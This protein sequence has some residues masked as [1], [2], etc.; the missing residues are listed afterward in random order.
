VGT[1]DKFIIDWEQMMADNHQG[2]KGPNDFDPWTG[3]K[4]EQRPPDLDAL[5]RKFLQQIKG[6]GQKQMPLAHRPQ[7]LNSKKYLIILVIFFAIWLVS[8]FF[9]VQPAERAVILRFGE[10]INTLGPGPHWIP[11]LIERRFI[12]NE[13]KVE[14]YSYQANMLT[15]DQTIVSVAISVFYR[16]GNAQAYLFNVVSPNQSLQQATASALR[17]VIGHN[18][19]DAV[20]TY[21]RSEIR[22]QVDSQLRTLLARYNTGL[23]ITDVVLQ[24][25]RAPEQ[26][27]AAFDDAIKAQEDEQRLINQAQAYAMKIVP[28]A[29][30]AAKRLFAEANAYKEKVTLQATGESTRFLALLNEYQK[31]P[32]VTRERLYLQTMEKILSNTNKVIVDSKQSQP[33]LYLPLDKMMQNISKEASA[34]TGENTPSTSATGLRTNA[35]LKATQTNSN[36]YP[37]WPE[38]TNANDGRDNP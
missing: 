21:G 8:G 35:S 15:K 14:T 32:R 23:I 12:V 3:R 11:P 20:L 4:R 27:K 29:E 13:E 16:V 28:L 25:A 22:Q 33:L 18:T 5:L 9:I 7:P 37:N 6:F 36:F 30:G 2:S 24:P 26:V 17:Q 34:E 10:Y 19:L 38:A 1:A 31:A